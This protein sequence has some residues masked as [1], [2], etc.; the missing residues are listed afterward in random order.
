MTCSVLSGSWGRS[1]NEAVAKQSTCVLSSGNKMIGAPLRIRSNSE[2]SVVDDPTA[3]PDHAGSPAD[4]LPGADDVAERGY[5]LRSCSGF[6]AG[7]VR[8]RWSPERWS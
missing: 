6:G 7:G 2:Y 4:G 1:G 5:P 8:C 3:G